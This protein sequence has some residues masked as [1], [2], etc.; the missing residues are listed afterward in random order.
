[1]V[2]PGAF[3]P[4][5]PVFRE[6]A[7]APGGATWLA[8]LPDVVVALEREWA[9]TTGPPY[10]DGVAAWTA[11]AMSADGAPAV[12]KVSWPHREARGEAA[13]LRFWDG[14]GAVHL[15]RSDDERAA[16][17]VERCAPGVALAA[18]DSPVEERLGVA[19]A[20]LERLWWRAPTDELPLERVGDV[21]REWADSAEQRHARLGAGLDDGLI[22]L[23]VALLR[24]LPA[25]ADRD[26]VVHGDCNPGNVLSSRR[27]PWLAIDPKPM[28]GDP[29]Y[30]LW[31]LITQLGAP[32]TASDPPTALAA[33]AR[34]A[35][36]FLGLPAD[37]ILAWSVA[38]GVES[39]LWEASR[40]QLE[41]A[42][43][44]LAEAAVL[45]RAGL[46]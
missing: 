24:E 29:S 3:G 43:R 37:R 27:R 46:L 6:L 12:L 23:G 16:L 36:Q 13:A 21:A 42:R 34:L 15:L 17:L 41:A 38:R 10:L 1:M 44:Q 7:S 35:G 33:R 19:A 39:A 26:V 25:S 8:R 45:A 30:D 28:V 20:V 22:G 14:D 32:F 31:P 40:G 11:P 2:D 5:V 4:H 18:V 9:V